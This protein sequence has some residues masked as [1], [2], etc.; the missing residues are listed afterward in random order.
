MIELGQLERRA[1]DFSRRHARVI[2]FS[3]DGVEASKKTQADFPHLLVLSDKDKALANALAI[4]H[5][6][7]AP[8]GADANMPTTIL[9]DRTGVVRWLHRPPSLLTPLSPDEVLQAVDEN[10]VS[11]HR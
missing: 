9:V 5:A 6:H 4:V 11:A 2:V 8:D 1:E 10:L 7:A 3:M